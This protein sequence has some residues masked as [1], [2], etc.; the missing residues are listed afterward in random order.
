MLDGLL[1]QQ[2]NPSDFKSTLAEEEALAYKWILRT[3]QSVHGLS[4]KELDFLF[5]AGMLDDIKKLWPVRT[6]PRKELEPIVSEYATKNYKE[7]F[8]ETF[9]FYFTKKKLPEPLKRL[10]EKSMSYAKSNREKGNEEE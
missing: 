2:D 4:V 7:L 6:I 1:S 5:E 8:A 3:I 9:A 10:L